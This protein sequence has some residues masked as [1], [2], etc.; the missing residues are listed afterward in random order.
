MG[1]FAPYSVPTR[2]ATMVQIVLDLAF[3]GLA[4]SVSA[5]TAMRS[6]KNKTA[7]EGEA[8]EQFF[9]G[10]PATPVNITIVSPISRDLV[11]Y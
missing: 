7:A 2:W 1:D 8:Q 10:E 5:G 4:V 11:H 9:V 3:F 6:V